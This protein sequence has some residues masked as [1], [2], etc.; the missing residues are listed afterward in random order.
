MADAA[1]APIPNQVEANSD[2]YRPRLSDQ[3]FIS[4]QKM[5]TPTSG[6]NPNANI[7]DWR[8]YAQVWD[9]KARNTKNRIDSTK[10]VVGAFNYQV[11]GNFVF[12]DDIEI[13][14]DDSSF[15]QDFHKKF[16]LKHFMITVRMI[17]REYYIEKL[18]FHYDNDGEPQEVFKY[19]W[20]DF[21]C[22]LGSTKEEREEVNHFF[23]DILSQITTGRMHE[24]VLHTPGD[25]C[26]A[27]YNIFASHGNGFIR[28][29]NNIKKHMEDL[30]NNLPKKDPFP[31]FQKFIAY[32]HLY[33]NYFVFN[34]DAQYM[35]TDVVK[36]DYIF[37]CLKCQIEIYDHMINSHNLMAEKFEQMSLENVIDDLREHYF[38]WK[39]QQKDKKKQLNTSNSG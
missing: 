19:E 38:E 27:Y 4:P 8:T 29:Q 21:E 26:S 24:I 30:K 3:T 11:N 36:N 7:A 32:M 33:N 6:I 18:V 9:S 1:L 25:G 35:S 15:H 23:Y 31:T 20:T 14:K 34:N 39:Q 22:C 17:L 13:L 10:N 37:E 12:A 5:A 16:N 28:K 2:R